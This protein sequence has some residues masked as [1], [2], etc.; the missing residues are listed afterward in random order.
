MLFSDRDPQFL[1]SVWK[2][3]LSDKGIV[4]K[5]T[6]GYYLEGNS[7]GKQTVQNL[8]QTLRSICFSSS[9]LSRPKSLKNTL[10][11]IKNSL[12]PLIGYSP[13]EIDV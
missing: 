1:S 3:S 5:L 4:L 11:S 7:M 2:R 9:E 13:H 10:L 6:S 8:V 12:I